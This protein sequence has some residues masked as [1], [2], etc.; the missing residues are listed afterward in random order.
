MHSS[1]IAIPPLLGLTFSL[2]GGIFLTCLKYLIF[3]FPHNYLTL[4]HQRRYAASVGRINL[5]RDKDK[6]AILKKAEKGQYDRLVFFH[7]IVDGRFAVTDEVKEKALKHL[8]SLSEEQGRLRSLGNIGK[9]PFENCQR[10]LLS[11]IDVHRERLLQLQKSKGFWDVRHE[12]IELEFDLN[13]SSVEINEAIKVLDA[14]VEL[15]QLA[16]TKEMG[17]LGV[18]S[19]G[20][21]I[22][23]WAALIVA[24]T[25]ASTA[26]IWLLRST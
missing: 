26:V 16:T 25:L 17:D 10:A 20:L 11:A 21:W 13:L 4:R 15:A 23:F 1:S 9:I 24:L 2:L 6:L 8:L 7:S 5:G 18:K 3:D 19:V 22:K 12:Q 14:Q